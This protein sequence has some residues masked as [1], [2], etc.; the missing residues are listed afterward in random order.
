MEKDNKLVAELNT[1][2]DKLIMENR[3]F[4]IQLNENE[5]VDKTEEFFNFAKGIGLLM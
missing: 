5:G 2:N 1:N 3:D 4:Y